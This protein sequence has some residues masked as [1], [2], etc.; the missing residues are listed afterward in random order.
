MK[1]LLILVA[2]MTKMI[3][4]LFGLLVLVFLHFCS[5][6]LPQENRHD[7]YFG[8]YSKKYSRISIENGPRKGLHYFD[9]SGIKYSCLYITTTITNDSLIPIRL[10]ISFS[11]EY[12]YLRTNN[13]LNSRVFLLPKRLIP[14]R[15]LDFDKS[16]SKEIKQF[17]D[18]GINVPISL[19][20]IIKPG[21][22]VVM[23]FG[24]LTEMKYEEFRYMELIASEK[25]FHLKKNDSLAS[26]LPPSE[27]SH[28]FYLALDIINSLL[29]PCGQISF[30][31]SK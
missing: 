16:M 6:E 15:Q 25:Q 14:E 13:I 11:K 21:E 7:K 2:E 3:K 28:S 26:L 29:I 10:I 24:V 1:S 19:D 22:R 30:L 4:Y 8:S 31:N 18:T 23:T 20:T 5:D 17:L 12:N 9:S 27:N